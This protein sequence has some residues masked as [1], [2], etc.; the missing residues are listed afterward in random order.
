VSDVPDDRLQEWIDRMQ[1]EDETARNEA[2]RRLIDL[3]AERLHR[4]AHRILRHS[5]PG[6]A[7]DHETGSVVNEFVLRLWRVPAEN[8]PPTV[9][10]FFRLAAW[11][12][13]NILLDMARAGARAAGAA[14]EVQLFADAA[15]GPEDLARWTEFHEQVGKLSE[16]EREVVNLCWY[17][18]L[19]QAEAARVLNI[20]PRE[21]S[22]RWVSA[23]ARLPDPEM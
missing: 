19:K 20:H 14:R 5:F 6:P 17:L 13:R 2:R 8:N 23:I 10:D 11:H 4:L 16:A 9:Q 18:G 12:M 22:R 21:V 3:A 15:E 1:A 7:R